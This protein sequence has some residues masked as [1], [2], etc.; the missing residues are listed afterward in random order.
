MRSCPV[1]CIVLTS[2]CLAASVRGEA[3][4]GP[5]KD[6]PELQVLKH[7]IG[8][9]DV[10]MTTR[11]N[12]DL[13][14][15]MRAKGPTTAEWVLDGRFVQQSGTLKP[16]DGSPALQAT[17]L[18]TY[19]PRKKVYRSWMF[20]STGFVSESEGK[21]D[22]KTRTLTSTSRDAESGTT[23]TTKATFAEDGTESWSIVSKDREGKVVNE[24]T[25][26]NT[27]RKK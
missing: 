19:D 20:F 10:E 2:F 14:R 24:T 11:P 7:W 5:S 17:T 4:Q 26:K 6:V 27:R 8:T 15:G 21:W 22:E 9:W 18:M 25:G 1:A 13:P 12:A 16:D 23:T 3:P